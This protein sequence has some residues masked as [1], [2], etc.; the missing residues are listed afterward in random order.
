MNTWICASCGDTVNNV[1]RV[2][3]FINR[4]Y[5]RPRQSEV[6]N[7][8]EQGNAIT[9]S[10]ADGSVWSDNGVI[11][12]VCP[13]C[14]NNVKM[15]ILFTMTSVSITCLNTECNEVLF[16]RKVAHKSTLSPTV[17]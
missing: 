9:Q 5:F 12:T 4:H 6:N 3:H 8:Q 11:D 16:Y 13:S 17:Q 10:E 1:D 15:Q 14:R 2:Q 7:R